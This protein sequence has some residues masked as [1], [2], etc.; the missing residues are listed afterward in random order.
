MKIRAIIKEFMES[1]LRRKDQRPGFSLPENKLKLGLHCLCL[2]VLMF[3]SI[4]LNI[5]RVFALDPI[6]EYPSVLWGATKTDTTLPSGDPSAEPVHRYSVSQTKGNVAIR[7]V[8]AKVGDELHYGAYCLVTGVYHPCFKYLNEQNIRMLNSRTY[9]NGFL[10]N[11]LAVIAPRGVN[12]FGE[13]FSAS[14]NFNYWGRHLRTTRGGGSSNAFWELRNYQF[15]PSAQAYWNSTATD[16]NETMNKTIE[17]LKTNAKAVGSVFSNNI[18]V[19]KP[20]YG[21]CGNSDNCSE[22]NQYPEGR[23][24]LESGGASISGDLLRYKYKAT[25]IVEPGDLAVSTNVV[26]NDAQSSLGFIVRDGKVTITN[27]SSNKMTIEASI[28][29]PKGTITISGNNIDLIGSFV[30]KDF[31]VPGSNINFIQDTRGET[32]FP[33]GFRELQIPSLLAK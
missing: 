29:A 10:K 17:R 6:D 23:V 16:K 1:G 31:S 15:N 32:A 25:L 30:A 7:N 12:V 9:I 24:W 27:S 5:G 22:T 3:F 13:S 33:P 18:W 26:K 8:A 19:Q 28:F 11:T 20:F 14:G 2:L 4:F 21:I